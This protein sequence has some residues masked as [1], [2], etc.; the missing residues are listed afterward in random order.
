MPLQNDKN[1]HFCRNLKMFSWKSCRN[2]K[3]LCFCRIVHQ[4]AANYEKREVRR[5]SPLL[6]FFFLFPIPYSWYSSMTI[7]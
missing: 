4:P 2:L 6:F 7:V 5:L 1:T 3:M